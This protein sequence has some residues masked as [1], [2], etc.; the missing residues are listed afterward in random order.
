MAEPI[1]AED[2]ERAW[3]GAWWRADFSWAGLAAKPIG[4]HG[5]TV[6][7]S[8]HG[9]KTLQDYWRRDPASGVVRTD[10]ALLDVGELI[11][12]PDGKLWHVVHVPQNWRDG[13]RAKSAW[14]G[15]Q[16]AGIEGVLVSRLVQ[17]S[18]TTVNHWCQSE[19]P[20]GR[21]QF[22]GAVCSALPFLLN[23]NPSALHVICDQSWLASWENVTRPFGD[24]ARF[25]EAFFAGDTTFENVIFEGNVSFA[26]ATFSGGAAFFGSRF[27][28]VADFADVSFVGYT[29]F[30]NSIFNKYANFDSAL[31]HNFA[32][33]AQTTFENVLRCSNTIFNE[34]TT[35]YKAT[36]VGQMIFFQTVFRKP[37]NFELITWPSVP[38][39]WHGA[40]EQAVFDDW[41]VFEGAGFR[42]LAAFADA[43]FKLGIRFDEVPE[44]DAMAIFKKERAGAIATAK[45]DFKEVNA[46]KT[47]YDGMRASKLRR[48]K[49][50]E[51]GCR[52]LKQAM[53]KASH[54]TREQLFYRFELMARRVQSDTPFWERIFSDLYGLTSGFGASIARPLGF[55]LLVWIPI[56]GVAYWLVAALFELD[57]SRPPSIG[58]VSSFG[59]HLGGDQLLHAFAF[60]VTRAFP[61]DLIGADATSDPWLA[62]V[63]AHGPLATIAIRLI[64]MFEAIG[65]AGLAFLSGLAVRR[66][67]QIN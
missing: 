41:A 40:F 35:F 50:L 8:I 48:L 33:F 66:R 31:F 46:A 36:F 4:R 7:G 29:S 45:A 58:A 49:E 5:D 60:S 26:G 64:G 12:D 28:G 23:H 14:G 25:Y 24:G 39:A 19:S 65:T 22:T 59:G 20:D 9:D 32:L 47:G 37:A 52:V 56:F 13:S 10:Q 42:S 55:L 34:Q 44:W 30:L 1:F 61:V 67:F 51:R 38:S 57:P 43:V 17:A 11:E 27:T 63:L 6:H 3:W 15:V 16:F 54:K 2:C 62:S 18:A 53:E 21:A